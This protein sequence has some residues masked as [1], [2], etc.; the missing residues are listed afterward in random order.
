LLIR[1]NTL[2][3]AVAEKVYESISPDAVIEQVIVS[4]K[5]MDGGQVDISAG[6]FTLT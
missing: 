3:P 1:T 2:S 5:P 6:L 4:P